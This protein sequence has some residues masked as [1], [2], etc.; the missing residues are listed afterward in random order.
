MTRLPQQDSASAREYASQSPAELAWTV[1]RRE[2]GEERHHG[3]L[4]E[5]ESCWG[6]LVKREDPPPPSTISL[7]A[8]GYEEEEPSVSIE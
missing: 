5:A 7:M 6:S 2:R 3:T 8:G 1:P 4:A